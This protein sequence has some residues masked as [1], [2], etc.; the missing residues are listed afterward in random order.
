MDRFVS[1]FLGKNTKQ[2]TGTDKQPITLNK[3][4]SEIEK[5]SLLLNQ[6][7]SALTKLSEEIGEE[8]SDFA[9]LDK[10]ACDLSDLIEKASKEENEASDALLCALEDQKKEVRDLIHSEN[11]KVYRNVQAVIV[12]ENAK[13]SETVNA[14]KRFLSKKISTSAAFSILSF[15]VAILILAFELIQYLGI[16]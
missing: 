9:R 8:R 16:I 14:S 1:R 11:V 7:N 2:K 12:D 5:L 4:A 13:L 6:Y 10:I 3:T 15:F